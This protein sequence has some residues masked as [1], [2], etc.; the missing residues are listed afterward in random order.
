LKNFARRA[1]SRRGA[2]RASAQLSKTLGPKF[3]LG[4]RAKKLSVMKMVLL[5][6]S[7]EG[8]SRYGAPKAKDRLGIGRRR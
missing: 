2:A 4:K 7:P 3:L 8:R 1:A 5:T 6:I